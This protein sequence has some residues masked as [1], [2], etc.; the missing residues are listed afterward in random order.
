M[1]KKKN[2]IKY[3][4][5]LFFLVLSGIFYSCSFKKEEKEVVS[6]ALEIMEE[7][8]SPT[9]DMEE[10]IYVHVCGAVKNPDVYETLV[11]T[12]VYEVITMAGGVTEDGMADALNLAE[13]VS[14]GQRITVPTYAEAEDL[15]SE[16]GYSSNGLVNINE[17]GEDVL[18]TL[19]GVGPAKAKSIIA[20]R[21]ENGS[22][23][24]IEDIMNITG[25]KEGLFNKIKDYISIH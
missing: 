6:E 2:L 7:E 1:A 14:D 15:Q 17:A 5:V 19:P 18:I 23:Q 3:C 24:S 25:I 21:E 8:T 10:V 12:R 13:L 9:E 16:S 4:F 11:G 22:F 20:Y